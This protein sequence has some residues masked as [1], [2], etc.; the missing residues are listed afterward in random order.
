MADK[1][2][3]DIVGKIELQ[4]I[5]NAVNQALRDISHRYD[6]KNSKYSLEFF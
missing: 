5:D 2:S 3:F 1:F 6:I 4:E